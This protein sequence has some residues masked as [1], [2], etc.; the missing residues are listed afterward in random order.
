MKDY[1]HQT[2]VQLGNNQKHNHD[3]FRRYN[4][5]DCLTEKEDE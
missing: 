1:W 3:L 4:M 2:L 5:K